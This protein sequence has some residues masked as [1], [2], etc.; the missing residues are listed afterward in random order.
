MLPMT[1]TLV[2]L[3]GKLGL[4]TGQGLFGVLRTR[5][6]PV[7]PGNPAVTQGGNR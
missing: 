6:S 7:R 3:S 2:Y 4:V 5:P 1:V